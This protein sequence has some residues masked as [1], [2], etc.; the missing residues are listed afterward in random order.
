MKTSQSCP[1]YCSSTF[2]TTIVK[3]FP[4]EGWWHNTSVPLMYQSVTRKPYPMAFLILSVY[5]GAVS[6]FPSVFLCDSRLA[7]GKKVIAQEWLLI[8]KQSTRLRACVGNWYTLVPIFWIIAILA[9]YLKL[10]RTLLFIAHERNFAIKLNL[11]VVGV[12]RID[13]VY[14]IKRD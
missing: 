13:S 5:I 14:V 11:Q 10:I 4:H 12:R 1:H 9:F 8:Y 7:G 2:V 3:K 6:V